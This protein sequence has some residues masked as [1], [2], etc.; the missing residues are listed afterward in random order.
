MPP[1]SFDFG[2]DRYNFCLK[3]APLLF[4]PKPIT[5]ECPEIDDV[6]WEWSWFSVRFKTCN[7]PVFQHVEVST[8]TVPP[9][10]GEMVKVEGLQ[11]VVDLGLTVPQIVLAMR[12]ASQRDS[13]QS[14]Q[15][16]PEYSQFI[17]QNPE[18]SP[19]ARIVVEITG[20]D[21]HGGIVSSPS[22]ACSHSKLIGLAAGDVC[23][24]VAASTELPPTLPSD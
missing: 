12:R 15:Q 4:P 17:Q 3:F 14:T 23:I 19:R 6:R 21:M 11:Q 22:I 10:L 9:R 7:M 16:H 8:S 1:P 18:C 13:D 2:T 5:S 20:T 24:W